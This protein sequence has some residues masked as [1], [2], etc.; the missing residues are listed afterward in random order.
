MYRRCLLILLVLL[1]A[2]AAFAQDPE[3]EAYEEEYGD[4]YGSEYAGEEEER[5]QRLETGPLK[6]QNRFSLGAGW[7]YAPNTNF[8]DRYYSRPENRGLTRADGTFGG[9]LMVGT[10]GHSLLEWL[11]LGID[12]FF[13]YERMAITLKPDFNTISFGMMFGVRAQKRFLLGPEDSFTPYAGVLS[14]PTFAA[15]YFAGSRSVE[16]F[17]QALGLTAGARLRL[18]PKWGVT[19]EYRLTFANGQAERL[20]VYNAG[21]SWLSV[22]LVYMFP[23]AVKGPRLQRGIP[24]RK[25]R[26]R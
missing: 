8:F 25:P 11:E 19:L 22:G 26:D 23:K 17:A 1:V 16:N 12:M 4:G 7:R 21:G 9:P 13:T 14:G 10:F 3:E 6:G 2:P 18:T 24:P 5:Q 15:S 20:G